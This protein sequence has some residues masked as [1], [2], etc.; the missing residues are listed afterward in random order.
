MSIELKI[1][2]LLAIFAEILAIFL[3]ALIK[4]KNLPVFYDT[5]K[6]GSVTT[7][8]IAMLCL[9]VIDFL[10]FDK[11]VMVAEYIVVA[12][13]GI[14]IFVW[15]KWI[16]LCAKYL[17][18]VYRGSRE[19]NGKVL[20]LMLLYNIAFILILASGILNTIRATNLPFLEPGGVVPYLVIGSWLM[21]AGL[22]V[23]TIWKSLP[24]V[25]EKH[26]KER[27]V[28]TDEKLSTLG[29]MFELTD[30][31]MTMIRYLYEGKNNEEVADA[32]GLSENTIKTYN[33]RLYKKLEV[34]S[35]VQAVNKI[36]EEIINL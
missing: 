5:I 26:L 12:Y 1:I 13:T 7:F 18:A 9:N 10:N 16:L 29:K 36:R 17:K 25:D 3:Q 34:E 15:L 11:D 19:K 6:G 21:L 24:I 30:R 31:E 8:L 23:V 28:L 2:Y 20:M 4:R 35:R 22:N 32:L 27:D 14:I 33:F